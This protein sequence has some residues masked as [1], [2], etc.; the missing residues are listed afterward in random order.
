MSMIG[1]CP[2]C[3]LSPCRCGDANAE[4]AVSNP[5]RS[6]KE[7]PS[8]LPPVR[9]RETRSV[10]RICGMVEN[11]INHVVVV[12]PAVIADAHHFEPIESMR[13]T[14]ETGSIPRCI[15][16]YPAPGQRD[17][18]FEVTYRCGLLA[19]HDGPHRAEIAEPTDQETP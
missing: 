9:E 19:G 17:E 14:P 15:G 13:E 11:N 16:R 2:I 7:E 6:A 5:E 12:G 3:Y 1:I 18:P 4:R 10:C 8:L